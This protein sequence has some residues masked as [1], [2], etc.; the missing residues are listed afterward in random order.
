[1]LALLSKMEIVARQSVGVWARR[2]Q[3]SGDKVAA[4]SSTVELKTVLGKHLLRNLQYLG[5]SAQL[6]A[7]RAVVREVKQ[8]GTN[9]VAT[10]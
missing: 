1:M 4:C 3:F 8:R 10:M 2:W 5:L 6:R 9:P 7:P